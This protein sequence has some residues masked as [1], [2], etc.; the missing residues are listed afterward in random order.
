MSSLKFYG[1]VDLCVTYIILKFERIWP[2]GVGD[3]MNQSLKAE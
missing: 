1:E 3:I 2:S